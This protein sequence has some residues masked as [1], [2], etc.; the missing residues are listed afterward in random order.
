MR[1]RRPP[2]KICRET[3]LS[4]TVGDRRYVCAPMSHFPDTRYSVLADLA[5]DD[6]TVRARAVELVARAYR[7]A[8]LAVLKQRWSLEASDAEDLTHDFFLHALDRKWLERYD[9]RKG[10]FRSFLRSCLLAYASTAHE[11]AHRLKRGGAAQHLTLDDAAPLLGDAPAVDA[12]FE[13]EWARGVLQIA[14]EAL[15]N[16]C[17]SASRETT[18]QL[19]LAHDIEGSELSVAPTYAE[20]AERFA[21]PRT[22]VTNFL[23]WARRRFRAHVV[24]TLRATTASEA[25]F[26]DEARALLGTADV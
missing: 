21:I 24:A 5:S 4:P 16:E 25:E 17:T 2:Q 23:N 14:L 11:S 26:R 13:R 3:S 15:H 18:W 6:Q 8:V 9:Q 19:F 10:R 22:Q 7:G 12:L 1:P 20:L